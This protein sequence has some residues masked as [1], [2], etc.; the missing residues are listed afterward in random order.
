MGTLSSKS[1][2]AYGVRIGRDTDIRQGFMKQMA[3]E[4]MLRV[5]NSSFLHPANHQDN[6]MSVLQSWGGESADS[7]DSRPKGIE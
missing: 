5:K 3:F 6:L 7:G 2:S 4:W 1:N